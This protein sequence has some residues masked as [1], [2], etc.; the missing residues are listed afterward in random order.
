MIFVLS[1]VKHSDSFEINLL[2]FINQY[3]EGDL[4]EMYDELGAWGPLTGSRG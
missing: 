2:A 3:K 1:V 4:I